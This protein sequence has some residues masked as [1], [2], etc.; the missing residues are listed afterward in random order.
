[1]TTTG[2]AIALAAVAALLPGAIHLAALRGAPLR[3]PL[4]MQKSRWERIL[5]RH[6]NRL[7]IANGLLVGCLTFFWMLGLTIPSA[8]A[9]FLACVTTVAQ[10]TCLII[11]K[12]R[13]VSEG[14]RRA[15]K[16]R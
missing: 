16:V 8:I 4:K 14:G 6:L 5:F 11:A 10:F 13:D 15:A 12:A 9:G 1:M 7:I 3:P 2:D